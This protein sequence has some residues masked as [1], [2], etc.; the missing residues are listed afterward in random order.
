MFKWLRIIKWY[1]IKW[2]I[3]LL[4]I[5]AQCYTRN[6]LWKKLLWKVVG[7]V[8]WWCL[9]W[10]DYTS[11]NNM[12]GRSL[13]TITQNL[14]FFRF[15]KTNTLWYLQHITSCCESLL[16]YINWLSYTYSVFYHQYCD[17][18][19]VDLPSLLFWTNLF[20]T[21]YLL[22]PISIICTLSFAVPCRFYPSKHPPPPSLQHNL[23]CL[24]K[25]ITNLFPFLLWL[26]TNFSF[27]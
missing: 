26:S 27:P 14:A 25:C 24:N 2:K 23:K 20:I 9:E 13:E 7:K 15:E 10:Y 21:E 4:K 12:I 1:F 22:H 6:T 8:N 19:D 17:W 16:Y 5:I 18:F 3:T 11:E